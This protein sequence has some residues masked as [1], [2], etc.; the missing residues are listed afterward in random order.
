MNILIFCFFTWLFSILAETLIFFSIPYFK[1]NFFFLIPT[2]LT[3]R[4]KGTESF[5]LY[6]FFGFTADSFGGSTLFGTFSISFFCVSFL[7]R[8]FATRML[9]E[10]ILNMLFFIFILNVLNT[11]ITHFL[12]W[13]SEQKDFTILFEYIFWHD[14]IP[15]TL[16]API[17][18]FLLIRLEQMLDIRL[19]ERRC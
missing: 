13:S 6:A 11:I 16:I 5:F 2:L 10:N 8:W 18:Y 15:T 4:W 3:F 17:L 7:S 9:H 1:P 14:C 12:L 19:A